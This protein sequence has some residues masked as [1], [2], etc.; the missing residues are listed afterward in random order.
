MKPLPKSNDTSAKAHAASPAVE[1]TELPPSMQPSMPVEQPVNRE[2]I[3]ALGHE[4]ATLLSSPVFNEAY[5]AT[6][7]QIVEQWMTSETT[8]QREAMWWQVQNLAEVTRQLLS[9]VNAA[10]ALNLSEAEQAEQDLNAY[11][12]EQGFL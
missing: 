2:E 5:R 11:Q 7:D 4:A 1:S 3:Q 9:H 12:D 6:M 8:E 10:Q